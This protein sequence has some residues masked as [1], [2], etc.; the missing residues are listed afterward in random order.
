MR[1]HRCTTRRLLIA[2]LALLLTLRPLYHGQA[3]AA[4]LDAPSPRGP[5]PPAGRLVNTVTATFPLVHLGLDRGAVVIRHASTTSRVVC[6]LFRQGADMIRRDR[7][8]LGAADARGRR[9]ALSRASAPPFV[10]GGA[11]WGVQRHACPSPMS[12]RVALTLPQS[13][14]GGALHSPAANRL[15]LTTRRVASMSMCCV[16]DVGGTG[17][18]RPRGGRCWGTAGPFPRPPRRAV[19]RSLPGDLRA[20]PTAW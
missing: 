3:Q 4:L 14:S 7:Q 13:A 2:T 1:L 5:L 10:V 9:C 6:C 8:R 12:E 11:C 20:A 15:F 18:M 17:D 16:P 19:I